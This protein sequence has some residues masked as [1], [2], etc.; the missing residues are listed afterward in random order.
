MKAIELNEW[1]SD[2][3]ARS[4]LLSNWIADKYNVRCSKCL[5]LGQITL[6][7]TDY[8][9]AKSKMFIHN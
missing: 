7:T 9:V 8:K 4:L 3:A 2:T 1:P 5:K 6:Q